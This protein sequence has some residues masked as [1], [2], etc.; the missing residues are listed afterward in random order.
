MVEFEKGKA[1]IGPAIIVIAGI[2]PIIN[3]ILAYLQVP[4]I[5]GGYDAYPF[6]PF[7]IQIILGFVILI[8]ITVFAR[9]PELKSERRIGNYIA[10]GTGLFELYG[11]IFILPP[12]PENI[13]YYFYIMIWI[14]ATLILIGAILTLIINDE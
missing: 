2:L 9:V 7:A 10:L 12:P 6:A 13:P 1:L 11:L 8:V 4:G 5:M 3:G 14:N